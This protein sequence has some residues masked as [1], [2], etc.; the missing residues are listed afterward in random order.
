[1]QR[2]VRSFATAVVTV[3]WSSSNRLVGL[4][5]SLEPYDT[6]LNYSR[7]CSKCSEAW[8]VWQLSLITATAGAQEPPEVSPGLSPRPEIEKQ[9]EHTITNSWSP[10]VPMRP[11]APRGPK[12][13]NKNNTQYPTA[14]A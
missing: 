9:K 1:M 7:A 4:G 5:S 13:T 2:S 14:K 11:R 3:W 12:L 10:G 8:S 6:I